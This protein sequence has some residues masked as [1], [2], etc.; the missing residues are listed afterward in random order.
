VMIAIPDT[1]I[2]KLEKTIRLDLLFFYASFYY[3]KPFKK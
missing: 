3:L 1:K 2:I